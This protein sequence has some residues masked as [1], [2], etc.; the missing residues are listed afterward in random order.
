ML[1]VQ[2]VG[3]GD[4]IQVRVLCDA[5]E[6][7]NMTWQQGTWGLGIWYNQS[8]NKITVLCVA[9]ALAAQDGRKGRVTWA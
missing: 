1:A 9:A 3:P 5:G 8:M 2:D 7:S 6:K 4:A